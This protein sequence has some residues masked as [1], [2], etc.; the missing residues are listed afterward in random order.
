[1]VDWRHLRFSSSAE[2]QG[3]WRSQFPLKHTVLVPK[4]EIIFSFRDFDLKP[5]VPSG[6]KHFILGLSMQQGD[7]VNSHSTAQCSLTRV[8]TVAIHACLGLLCFV[9]SRRKLWTEGFCSLGTE[10]W[11]MNYFC[12][13]ASASP[14]SGYAKVWGD[15]RPNCFT[16]LC[17]LPQ[18][19]GSFLLPLSGCPQPIQCQ[20]RQVSHMQSHTSSMNN[21]SWIDFYQKIQP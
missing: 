3:Q 18:D 16:G 12:F 21:P 15:S 2:R 4:E 6:Q 1:M 11:N 10:G 7:S 14:G 20:E 17:G 19:L 5:S 9:S 8:Y 13:L